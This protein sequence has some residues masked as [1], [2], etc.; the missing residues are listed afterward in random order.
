[1]ILRACSGKFTQARFNRHRC[2]D[3]QM[4]VF[5]T[6]YDTESLYLRC[7][8]YQDASC[9]CNIWIHV[10]T[11]SSRGITD[12]GLR[13]WKLSLNHWF[14]LPSNAH[15]RLR[16]KYALLQSFKDPVKQL[17]RTCALHPNALQSS[18]IRI[19]SRNFLLL[20]FLFMCA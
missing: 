14:T 9:H 18:E 2:A 20:E 10:F 11:I 15:S 5:T 17:L 7:G 13:N 6:H 3:M 4:R 19:L 1:M 12:D 16:K 8:W